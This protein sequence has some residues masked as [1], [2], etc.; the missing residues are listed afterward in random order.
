MP[1]EQINIGLSTFG[2]TY[3]LA[4]NN[5]RSINVPIAGL[6]INNGTINYGDICA[7][8]RK[9]ETTLIYNDRLQVPFAYNGYDLIAFENEK[10][11]TVKSRYVNQQQFGGVMLFALNF[12]DYNGTCD[13]RGDA[14]ESRQT[15]P[16]H[17]FVYR[18]LQFGSLTRKQ[19]NRL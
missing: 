1:R 3:N 4:F 15:F 14:N 10:S 2:R 13:S 8:V 11:L 19:F 6:G 12:D 9:D 18:T 7:F 16:L 17:N 5:V